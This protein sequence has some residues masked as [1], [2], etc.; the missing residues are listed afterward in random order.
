V[1]VTTN[2]T[3]VFLAG[4]MARPVRAWK[5]YGDLEH[6]TADNVFTRISDYDITNVRLRSVVKPRPTLSINASLVTKNNDNPAMT[7]Q[8]PPQNFGATI[9]TRIATTSVDW[10]PRETVSFS[11]GYTYTDIDSNAAILF[12][13]NSVLQSGTSLYFMHDHAVFANVSMRVHPRLLIFAGY[14]LDKD[15]GQGDQVASSPT[16]LIS[17]YPLRR[18]VPEG[19]VTARIV[20]NVDWITSWQHQD[21]AEQLFP[22]QDYRANVIYT[23]LR[24]R[25]PGGVPLPHVL[26]RRTATND[27]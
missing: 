20:K 25:L 3:N 12:Y 17:S 8:T 9:K 6:G 10:T 15:T 22:I 4:F 27:Y 21:Y 5:L 13:L 24:F 26:A 19:R 14:R 1:D 11:A 23:S 16:E 7:L 2:T 18:L